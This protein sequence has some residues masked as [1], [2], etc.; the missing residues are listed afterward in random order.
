LKSISKDLNGLIEDIEDT[1]EIIIQSPI[2]SD[3]HRL[4]LVVAQHQDNGH[5]MRLCSEI[6]SQLSKLF[7]MQFNCAY[8]NRQHAARKLIGLLEDIIVV[9]TRNPQGSMAWNRYKPLLGSHKMQTYPSRFRSI[10][11]CQNILCWVLKNLVDLAAMDEQYKAIL[12]SD[13][14]VYKIQVF[15]MVIRTATPLRYFLRHKKY[16]TAMSRV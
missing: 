15:L 8:F 14:C 5:N 4:A 6:Y 1:R 11:S 13:R 16:L 10:S 7:Q 3:I 9:N 2:S 12:L